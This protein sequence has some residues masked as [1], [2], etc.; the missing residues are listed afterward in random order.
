MS[1]IA[2]PSPSRLAG[3]DSDIKAP[4]RPKALFLLEE[5]SRGLIYGPQEVIELQRLAD[6]Y[7]DP[8]TPESIGENLHVL[9]EAE[10]IFSGWK[11]PKMDRKFL[12]SAPNLKA[13][14]YGAGTIG[15]FVTPEFWNRG[16][17]ITSAYAANAVPVAE[18]T[19]SVILLSL[20]HFWRYAANARIKEAWRDQARRV[21][22][23]FRSTVA[24]IACGMIGRKVIELLKPFDLRCIAYDPYLTDA[25]ARLLG[26][27]RCSMEDAFLHG[28]VVSL[29]APHKAETNGLVTGRH[30]ASMKEGATFINTARGEIVREKEMIDVLR[31]RPDLTAVVDV[32]YPEPPDASSPLFDVPN[33]IVSPHIAGSLG[34]EC[35][36]L[37]LFMVQEFR[38][39]LAGQPLKWQITKETLGHLA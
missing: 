16:I 7:T 8:Q 33:L 26:V 27:E 34:P 5:E 15:Y 35:R 32:C 9:K 37:G 14:F 22:G 36:R 23:G 13:V 1:Q 12:E 31:R 17:V 11:A 21:P 25:E 38:R 4:A 6:F 20:K 39:Y 24:V 30:I 28:D 18:Y 29:H 10:V 2:P 19:L 3:C